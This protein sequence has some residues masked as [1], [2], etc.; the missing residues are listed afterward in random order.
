M[1]RRLLPRIR[2]ILDEIRSLEDLAVDRGVALL[3][4]RLRLGIIPTIAP[5]LLPMLIPHL[6]EAY[7]EL[8]IELRE[9]LPR[10]WSRICGLAISTS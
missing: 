8:A 5:Y 3:R 9:A 4:G 1:G 7:P 6:R 10:S 2:G